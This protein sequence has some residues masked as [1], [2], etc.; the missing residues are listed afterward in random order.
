MSTS[1]NEQTTNVVKTL[2]ETTSKATGWIS[3][4]MRDLTRKDPPQQNKTSGKKPAIG[5]LRARSGSAARRTANIAAR[6]AMFEKTESAPAR[7][8]SQTKQRIKSS[9]FTVATRSTHRQNPSSPIAQ[10]RQRALAKTA[11]K[12]KPLPRKPMERSA[13]SPNFNI[14]SKGT[15]KS[16]PPI[17][18]KKVV[19]DVP[20]P[21]PTPTSKTTSTT[22][23]D[24]KRKHIIQEVLQSENKYLSFLR[25]MIKVYRDPLYEA[26]DAGS[27]KIRREQV[28]TMFCNID[29]VI[30]V[31][32]V[33]YQDV[34]STIQASIDSGSADTELGTVFLSLIP[35]LKIYK[36][37]AV[38]Y[39]QAVEVLEILKD[40]YTF[41]PF[42]Q[43]CEFDNP[44]SGGQKLRSLLIMPLQRIPRFVLLL[45]D[46]IKHTPE[47]HPD[48]D[49]VVKALAACK[50]VADTIDAA[51][52]EFE[53]TK[54][55]LRLQQSF[56]G[57]NI[58][59]V[60]PHRKLVKEGQIIKICRAS[61]QQRQFIL[62]ND[63]LLYTNIVG[64]RFVMPR[65][66]SLPSVHVYDIADDES[67][68]L[69][70]A[71]AVQSNKKSF[72]ALAED[73]A[74][75]AAWLNAFADAFNLVNQDEETGTN[76]AP[77]W[78]PDDEAKKCKRC[79]VPFTMFNRKHHC[80]KC[81]EVVC[82]TCSS[83]RKI[84]QNGEGAVRV[85]DSC[86]PQI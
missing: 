22:E 47:D 40:S 74:T 34:S 42:L 54:A 41:Q 8:Q 77:I 86:Y 15:K 76:V 12:P 78:R 13:S 43:S 48:Y 57:V 21:K 80:R 60:Q 27:V 46:L 70:N 85:C 1:I 5:S 52:K 4:S 61:R 3:K 58:D 83:Q 32:T 28:D 68:D 33:L 6:S 51:V 62:C 10:Q 73:A 29:D 55:L 36:T 81:G 30:R 25:M 14:G 37:Y 72:V 23:I 20:K 44:E 53:N 82:G 31:N 17:P 9:S 7:V 16:A 67:K 26:V 84:I 39:T 65:E 79:S 69:F 45:S 2:N 56:M 19:A 38:K 59:L 66:I 71:F 18:Q 75:K 49:P 11:P 50:E 35:Y 24:P 64:N 63:I